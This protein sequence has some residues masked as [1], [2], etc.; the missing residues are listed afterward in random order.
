MAK[1]EMYIHWPQIGLAVTHN[2]DPG[3]EMFK[4]CFNDLMP[5]GREQCAHMLE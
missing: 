2:F 5:T 4:F 1:F 3:S